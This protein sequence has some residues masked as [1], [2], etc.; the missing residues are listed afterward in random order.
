M[1]RYY[2]PRYIT[3]VP[4]NMNLTFKP[5]SDYSGS[6]YLIIG[7]HNSGMRVNPLPDGGISIDDEWIELRAW[8]VDLSTLPE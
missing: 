1:K 6:H 5:L 8:D 4:C 2:D 3:S 7:F